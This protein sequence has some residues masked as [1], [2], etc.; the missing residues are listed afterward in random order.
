MKN[1]LYWCAV[2]PVWPALGHVFVTTDLYLPPLTS[3]RTTYAKL[4]R[5]HLGN[6]YRLTHKFPKEML[7]F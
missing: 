2:M 4:Q 6:V 1:N 3:K 7:L 5:T